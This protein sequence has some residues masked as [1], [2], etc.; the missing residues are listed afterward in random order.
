MGDIQT[1]VRGSSR[2]PSNGVCAHLG[3]DIYRCNILCGQSR[4]TI[5]TFLYPGW[6]DISS[7]FSSPGRQIEI[8]STR[9]I[10]AGDARN[11]GG[12]CR[13]RRRK[14]G[15]H[16]HCFSISDRPWTAR[17]PIEL[18][19]LVH[20]SRG[21]GLPDWHDS[22]CVETFGD[23]EARDTP[24]PN[25]SVWDLESEIPTALSNLAPWANLG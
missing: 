1:M 14:L 17:R 24:Y 19:C 13:S 3:T 2:N 8:T 25:Q 18:G 22:S 10:Y 9:Q 20:W 7:S 12:F 11:R 23:M 21:N 4:C 15:E 5:S 6:C 16:N